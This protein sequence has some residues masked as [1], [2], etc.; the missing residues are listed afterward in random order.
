MTRG[1]LQ[2]PTLKEKRYGAG[3]REEVL[4]FVSKAGDG[5]CAV[6]ECK[7]PMYGMLEMFI[8]DQ[9]P[10]L[11]WYTRLLASL[12]ER[13]WVNVP[14]CKGHAIDCAARSVE[15]LNEPDLWA[16]GRTNPAVFPHPLKLS[17]TPTST[18]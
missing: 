11:D 17:S 3:F 13:A 14:L 18:R 6:S 7:D 4:T 15:M 2:G 5:T 16:P 12:P 8:D 1:L 10:A 9:P